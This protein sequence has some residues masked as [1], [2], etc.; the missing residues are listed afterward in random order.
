MHWKWKLKIQLK[1]CHKLTHH[2]DLLLHPWTQYQ[3]LREK[4]LPINRSRDLFFP[5]PTFDK[6]GSGSLLSQGKA[7]FDK[8]RLGSLPSQGK[9]TFNKQWL[10][11]LRSEQSRLRFLLLPIIWKQNPEIFNRWHTKYLVCF[12][13]F[14]GT[15]RGTG[16]FH[17][18]TTTIEFHYYFSSCFSSKQPL[19][20][21]TRRKKHNRRLTRLTEKAKT[22]III[23]CSKNK[24]KQKQLN[25]EKT[26]QT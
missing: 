22:I 19:R 23:M 17:L 25:E 2:W 21:L 14:L 1:P 12:F 10:G 3:D 18:Q 6:P 5:K 11:S 15:H 24:R 9:T 8:P 16:R 20:N 4:Q 7:T 13:N 26:F